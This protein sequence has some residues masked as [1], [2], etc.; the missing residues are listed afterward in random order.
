MTC[1]LRIINNGDGW[2]L[3]HARFADGENLI[4]TNTINNSGSG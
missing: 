2:L 3:F 1:V 4:I